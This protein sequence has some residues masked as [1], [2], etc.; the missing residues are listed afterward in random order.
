MNETFAPL[1][2][3]EIARNRKEDLPFL[4]YF[5]EMMSSSAGGA[6]GTEPPRPTERTASA[7]SSA[8]R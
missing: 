8:G 2:W 3:Q 6:A 4:R 5:E 1:H 7:D